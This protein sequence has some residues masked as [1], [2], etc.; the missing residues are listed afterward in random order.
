MPRVLAALL[1]LA[2][3]ATLSAC[4]NKTHTRTEG[5]TE[6]VYLDVGELRYQVQVSRQLNPLSVDDA[7]Y[8]EGLSP[9]DRQLAANELWFGVWLLV[10]NPSDEG[11]T[12]ATEFEIIDT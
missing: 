2:L 6:G 9:E 5:E 1:S 7:P 8:L 10:Q 11:Q 12:A 3:A 4:G